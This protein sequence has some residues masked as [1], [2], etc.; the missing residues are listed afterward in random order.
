MLNQSH[1][2]YNS[3]Y[4]APIPVMNLTKMKLPCSD[5]IEKN[6]LNLRNCQSKFS[7]ENNYVYV[8]AARHF[9]HLENYPCKWL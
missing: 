3:C 7:F 9:F 8:K 1:A 4:A 5:K 6:M 2:S